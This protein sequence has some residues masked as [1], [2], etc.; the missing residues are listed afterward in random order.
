[1]TN[2]I[3]RSTVSNWTA[4]LKQARARGH[5]AIRYLWRIN[6]SSYP[7]V[8]MSLRCA[9]SANAPPDRRIWGSA[10]LPSGRSGRGST[11][12]WAAGPPRVSLRYYLDLNIKCRLG[13]L[14]TK[15]SARYPAPYCPGWLQLR[16]LTL[17]ECAGCSTFCFLSSWCEGVAGPLGDCVT[18][19]VTINSR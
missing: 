5:M 14:I 17:T 12:W 11:M 8:S 6:L 18:K 15:D 3:D 16:E 2:P 10:S 7:R 4:R 1:M 13:D 19:D 9:S